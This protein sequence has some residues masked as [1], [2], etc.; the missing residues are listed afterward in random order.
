MAEE[1]VEIIVDYREGSSLPI[2]EELGK[3]TKIKFE[4]LEIGDYL[5]GD[6]AIERK[7]HDFL[8]F[9]RLKVQAAILKNA[10]GNKAFL[11]VEHNLDDII[12]N[13]GKHFNND[14][15]KQ[16]LGMVASLAIREGLVPI[17]CSNPEYAAYIIHALCEKGNDGKE[18]VIK[19]S[20]PRQSHQDRQIHFLCG[21]PGVEE[22][23]AQR[24]LEK[25]GTVKDI[26]NATVEQ[27][28][29]VEGVGQKKAH[30]IMEVMTYGFTNVIFDE[31]I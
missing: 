15:T 9:K 13:S 11:V 4:T 24:L 12:A 27:I 30:A 3:L 25:F 18:S 5:C 14:K 20:R 17:F 7:S 21:I 16:I 2:L 6:V 29:K 31:K 23:L 1:T 22:V 19:K 10:Y 8:D 28:Q 26:A